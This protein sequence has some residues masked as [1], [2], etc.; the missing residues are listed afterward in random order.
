MAKRWTLRYKRLVLE[1]AEGLG[2]DAKAE[3][4]QKSGP[5]Q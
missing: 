5:R 1:I 4:L 2:N 3:N